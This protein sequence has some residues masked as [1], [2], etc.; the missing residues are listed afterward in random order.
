MISVMT[1]HTTKFISMNFT[2]TANFILT[3]GEGGN[4][5]P[6]VPQTTKIPNEQLLRQVNEKRSRI[7]KTRKRKSSLGHVMKREK[8]ENMI[9]LVK[10]EGKRGRGPQ[11]E[12]KLE[13]LTL[14]CNGKTSATVLLRYIKG[15][16]LRR[17]MTAHVGP[18]W[19]VMMMTFYSKIHLFQLKVF[20]SPNLSF[21]S[22]FFI[23]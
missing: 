16:D 18:A 6:S 8:L 2:F 15:R 21:V 13:Y 22:F 12:Q 3:E 10:T 19:H 23:V 1:V 7:T 17:S 20:L 4:I 14:L 9:T 11:R 5:L